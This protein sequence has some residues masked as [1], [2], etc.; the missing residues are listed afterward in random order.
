MPWE[1]EEMEVQIDFLDEAIRNLFQRPKPI[2]E[3]VL[4]SFNLC[5]QILERI[6]DL[7]QSSL[8]TLQ[9]S[10]FARYF[11]CFKRR[12]GI[13]TTAMATTSNEAVQN[14]YEKSNSLPTET[15]SDSV[16]TF[17]TEMVTKDI[18]T[19]FYFVA[20]VQVAESNIT[21]QGAQF[22]TMSEYNWVSKGTLEQL[23]L[24]SEMQPLKLSAD[25]S[26]I[27]HVAFNQRKVEPIGTITLTWFAFNFP[28]PRA[29]RTT[30][31][32]VSDQDSFTLLIGSKF[33]IANSI[34]KWNFDFVGKT[35]HALV[36]RKKFKAQKQEQ[37][38]R[39]R[40]RDENDKAIKAAI[41]EQETQQL[42]GQ[43]QPTTPPSATTTQHLRLKTSPHNDEHT[44]K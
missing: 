43:R 9:E 22:D 8:P 35:V 4:N 33:I 15:P 34:L 24:K 41:D 13:L 40:Q 19:S 14:Q 36:S 37:K 42:G 6:E 10:E 12:F 44:P 39:A 23:G 38:E 2:R 32:L 30:Q 7:R 26:S 17:G 29:S 20:G 1:L 31:F 16:A 25:M 28:P 18:P 3:C 5:Q 21:V 11:A 27:Q